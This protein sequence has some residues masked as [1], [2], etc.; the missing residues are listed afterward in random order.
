MDIPSPQ[1]DSS[2][3]P[4]KHARILRGP[5]QVA[6]DITNRCN[7]KCRHCYNRS[8]ENAL[9]KDELSDR[10]VKRLVRDLAHLRPYNVCFCGGETLLRVDLLCQSARELKQAGVQVSMVSNGW[11]LDQEVARNLLEAGVTRVQISVDGATPETHAFLRVLPQSFE[12]A[13]RA[14]EHLKS[15]GIPDVG[16][17]F[18]PTRNNCHQLAD[19]YQLCKRLGAGTFRVQPLMALGR[20][21][22]ELRSLMPTPWQY[23]ELLWSM[24][25]LRHTEGAPIEWGD[26]ID[27]LFR[28]SSIAQHCIS[29]VTI[30]ANG[31]IAL[32]P[33]LPV[34]IGNLRRHS[35]REYWEKG[36][37]R[38]WEWELPKS[39]ARQIKCMGDLGE[40]RE[41]LPAVWFDDSL[42]FD[43]IDDPRKLAAPDRTYASSAK[44]GQA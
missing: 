20:A 27:H 17:A 14:I 39:F 34:T 44:E 8:A 31:N 23:R 9:M 35:L 25:E 29:F 40:R 32:S 37:A 11:F 16:V 15:A 19:A 42:E 43:L 30:Q 38:I 12:R 3:I 1:S 21:S 4:L 13:T 2:A 36:L 10:E 6:F 28:F 7:L 5:T 18:T 26:P 24:N 22:Q 41:G 33:Y